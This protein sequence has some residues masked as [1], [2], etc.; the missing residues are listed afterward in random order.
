MHSDD[1][2]TDPTTG[3]TPAQLRAASRA[4]AKAEAD[5]KAK[6]KRDAY[7]AGISAATTALLDWRA[8][9]DGAKLSAAM[10]LAAVAATA[11]CEDTVSGAKSA[12]LLTSA[13]VKFDDDA[14]DL[15]RRGKDWARQNGTFLRSGSDLAVGAFATGI[16][17]KPSATDPRYAIG[18]VTVDHG[19]HAG[20]RLVLLISTAA[21]VAGD[22]AALAFGVA[23]DHV[24]DRTL[25]QEAAELAPPV[26]PGTV[27]AITVGQGV[28][29]PDDHGEV[30][31][32][33]REVVTVAWHKA[34][35]TARVPVANLAGVTVYDSLAAMLAAF[36][37]VVS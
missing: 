14:V 18:I 32:V 24:V 26:Y 31:A 5:A 3:L 27:C 9:V 16:A 2:T 20:R 12:A 33:E 37:G 13:V 10:E 25:A 34:G 8:Q 7:E 11:L 28:E 30:L 1:T 17:H 15:R 35:T 6:A 4:A 21:I 29:V 22:A 19:P 23:W 36:A